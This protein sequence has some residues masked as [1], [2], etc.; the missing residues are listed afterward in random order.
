MIPLSLG[1]ILYVLAQF[2]PGC[3]Q[4]YY[5]TKAKLI[6]Q[7]KLTKLLLESNSMPLLTLEDK[8][9]VIQNSIE[10]ALIKSTYANNK[11][12][13]VELLKTQYKELSTQS[14][15]DNPI[16]Y[17]AD[18]SMDVAFKQKDDAIINKLD[19]LYNELLTGSRNE[20]R[21]K[22]WNAEEIVLS[23]ADYYHQAINSQ[24]FYQF[25]HE[26]FLTQVNYV[27][28]SRYV[29]FF[30]INFSKKINPIKGS[31]LESV[32]Q[33]VD[34]IEFRSHFLKAFKRSN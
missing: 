5:T 10:K 22:D 4:F 24:V 7:K 18:E 30:P 1:L 11:M 25:N 13:Y 8:S 2:N 33:M 20:K 31:Y 28:M 23:L 9:K 21:S 14:Y 17:H 3:R 12:P 15:Y 34:K 6:Y 26:I 32:A 19:G 16:P 27:L 29:H